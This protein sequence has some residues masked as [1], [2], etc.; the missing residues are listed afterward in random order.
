MRKLFWTLIIIVIALTLIMVIMGIIIGLQRGRTPEVASPAPTT[1]GLKEPGSPTLLP[2]EEGK[3]AGAP[4]MIQNFA[5]NPPVIQI[6]A[7]QSVTWINQDAAAHTATLDDGSQTTPLFA[8]GES[9]TLRFSNP[10]T[11]T[12]HCTP[13]SWMTGTV[14]VI[15]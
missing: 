14:V 2:E 10:G 3:M 6:Q 5:F 9:A 8:Q 15:E 4:V 7:G 12:Y 11:Y 13:H 1:E